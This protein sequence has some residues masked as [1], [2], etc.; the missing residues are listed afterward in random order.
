MYFPP[1]CERTN[2][3][4][5]EPEDVHSIFQKYACKCVIFK[6]KDCREYYIATCR[7]LNRKVKELA[8]LAHGMVNLDSAARD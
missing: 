8:T 7:K 5:F 4:G 3:E 6:R 1:T 2:E